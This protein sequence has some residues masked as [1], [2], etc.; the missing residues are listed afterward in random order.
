MLLR[1]AGLICTLS[2]CF[3]V[4]TT[5]A[6]DKKNDEPKADDKKVAIVAHIRLNG[7]LDE[8]PTSE[9]SLFGSTSENFRT[10]L[11]RIR[12]AKTDPK[13]QA[14]WL[15]LDGLEL[16]LFGFGKVH[17]LRM[18]VQDFRKSGKKAYAYAE[19]LSSKELLIALACDGVALPPGGELELVGLRAEVTFFKDLFDKLHIQADFLQ[20]GDFKGAAEPFTRNSM[21]P[22][23]RK[24][25]EMVLDDYFENELLAV[26]VAA[27]PARKWTIEQMRKIIDEG[28]FTAKKAAELGLIDRVAYEDEWEA[29]IQADLKVD[30][31]KLEKDYGKAKSK[32][33]DFSNPFAL[34][35]MLSPKKKPASKKPK[36]AVIYAVG[37][38]ESGKG[39]DS[40]LRGSSVGST[41]MIAAI[42]EA[43]NDPTVHAIVLRVDSPGGSALASDLI[44]HELK[45]C[46]KPVVASMGDVAASGGYYISMAARKIFAEPGTLTGSIGVV[47]G[48]MVPSG[49]MEMAG[50]KREVIARGKNSGV[51]SPFSTFSDSER[52]AVRTLMEAIYDDFLNKALE[53]RKQAGV[54]MTREDLLKLAGGRIWT[55]RQ[56]KARG[57]VD[58]LGTL[59]DAI[60]AAKTLAD[61]A[62]DA[63]LELLILP[64]PVNFLEKLMD[65]DGFGLRSSLGASLLPQLGN[66]PRMPAELR[67]ALRI[68]DTMLRSRHEKVWLIAPHPLKVH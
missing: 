24:Q 35:S 57:L 47:G 67:D 46:K 5:L 14:L 4:P 11:D 36:I 32:E 50:I 3:C 9:E 40:L 51:T 65:G 26:L 30:K 64:K 23:N 12:Q 19:G 22:E 41:T 17:E 60:T 25:Y 27:R 29:F 62:P 63:N 61:L 59:D 66:Q 7:S 53:G 1:I 54:A 48:K 45:R 18:A 56:A 8:A 52:Q 16:D 42:R 6:A 28:P 10:K 31:L 38:I 13:V 37:E 58:A 21:S 43:E 20:M 39:G 33:P 34:L 49:L 2:G 68:I 55:G 44:W 15:H